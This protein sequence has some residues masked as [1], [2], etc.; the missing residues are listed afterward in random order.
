M[1]IL[2]R[3]EP[4]D[5]AVLEIGTGS[6]WTAGLLAHRLGSAV[7][8]IEVD[9]QFA[10]QAAA[11]LGAAGLRPAVVTGDGADGY[12]P[13]APYDRVHV[14]CG[15]ASDPPDWLRQCRPGAII[16]APWLPDGCGGHRLRLGVG[17]DGS[18]TGTFHGSCR[19]MMMRSQLAAVATPHAEQARPSADRISSLL[20]PGPAPGMQLML[21]AT[22]PGVS[23][24]DITD[25]DGSF[26][27]LLS[28]RTPGRSWAAADLEH[29]TGRTVVTEY[30]DRF[31]VGRGRER[32]SRLARRRPPRPGPVRA[33]RYRGGAVPVAR[34]AQAAHVSAVARRC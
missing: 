4:G 18:A 22:L 25:P 32:L 23:R 12:R 10:V 9:P 21:A 2:I 29:G 28:E 33:D 34:S 5:A 1:T 11:A 30:G 6:G 31:P 13:A 27:V 3:A 24:A 19:Y 16:V 8:S 20:I 15:I 7:T 17:A 26:S 14:T